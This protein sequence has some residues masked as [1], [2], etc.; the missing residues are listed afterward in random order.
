MKQQ[1][2]I[3]FDMDETLGYFVEFGIFWDSLQEYFKYIFPQNSLTNNDFNIILEK[4]PEFIRPNMLSI[5]KYLKKK[6]SRGNLSQVL[7]YTNNQGPKSWA[8]SIK[9]FF[10]YKLSYNLF[11]KVIGA[12]KVGG[13][14]VEKCRSSNHK[15]IYDLINCGKINKKNY[16]IC[17]IDDQ[18]HPLMENENVKYIKVKPYVKDVPFNTMINKFLNVK[19]Y[20]KLIKDKAFFRKFI[21]DY[22]SLYDYTFKNKKKDEDII[23]NIISKKMMFF[24]QDF[25]KFDHSPKTVKR[26]K[27]IKTN[28]TRKKKK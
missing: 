19:K 14:I 7:I 4:Y 18:Y 13:Q 11:D 12:Y 2:I 24:I 22:T 25:F 10:H 26:K 1:N 6:K 5:L 27:K 20:K 3:V 21:L 23:D 15:N 8:V 9:D 16:K 17:F 28:K